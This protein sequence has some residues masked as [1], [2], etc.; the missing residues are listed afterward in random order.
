MLKAP[1]S[2]LLLPCLPQVTDLSGALLSGKD[3]QLIAS[4]FSVQVGFAL[5]I[6]SAL[7]HVF[8]C[9]GDV[10]ASRFKM[11]GKPTMPGN[12]YVTGHSLGGALAQ[13]FVSSVTLGTAVATFSPSES[14]TKFAWKNIKLVTMSAPVAGDEAWAKELSKVLQSPSLSDDYAIGPANSRIT[15]RLYDT[16]RP[17]A[18]RVL[19]SSDPITTTKLGG[20]HV[21]QTVFVDHS[22]T[23]G[24]ARDVVCRSGLADGHEPVVVRAYLM[25]ALADLD[26]APPASAMTYRATEA[27]CPACAAGNVHGVLASAYG[28]LSDQGYVTP[29]TP[30]Y[31]LTQV[32]MCGA[33]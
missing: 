2:I 8:K 23:A 29:W 22:S 11:E 28:R 24:V 10:Q 14:V 33:T 17:A 9:I 7:P 13:L 27:L 3:A 31:L 5:A 1:C 19:V 20:Y 15:Q 12:I 21:G 18:F 6:K 26:P 16:T 32:G 30:G 25:A 4:A